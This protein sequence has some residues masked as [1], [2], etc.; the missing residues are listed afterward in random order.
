MDPVITATIVICLSLLFAISAAHKL[1]DPSAFQSAM[2]EYRLL[3][4]AL[5][6]IMA[7]ILIAS[8]VIASVLV[9][10]PN[11]RN[12][13]FGFILTLLLVYTLGI[14]FNLLRGRRDIDCGC[15]GPAAKQTLSWWLVSRNL[16]FAVLGLI[17]MQATPVRALNWL[18][19]LTILFAVLVASGLFLC[20]NQMLV[21]APGLKRLRNYI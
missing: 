6:G 4:P 10:I 21:Q 13:G 1:R 15:H 2:E 17:A 16:V 5:L 20:M 14:S 7:K 3:P 8:E 11:T 19:L 9:L 12:V 18:D